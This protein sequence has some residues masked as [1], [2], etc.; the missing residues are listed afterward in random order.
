VLLYGPPWDDPT[1]LSKHHLASYLARRGRRVL[2]VEAPLGPLSVL[3]R[4]TAAVPELRHTLQAPRAVEPNLWVRRYFN[5]VPYHSVTRA[6]ATRTANL[7]GQRLL[8]R[9]LRDDLASLGFRDSLVIAGLPHALD[10]LPRLP[11]PRLLV[12]HCA[13]DYASVRGF[14]RSLST[15]EAELCRRADL[16]I[17]TSEPLCRARRPLNPHTHWIP[18]GAN[19][20]HFG[21]PAAPAAELQQATPRPTV[22]F[23]GAIAQWVDLDLLWFL[24]DIRPAW[25]LVLVGPIGQDVS[26]LRRLPNVH[27]LGPRPYSS[28]PSFLAAMD[29]A[30]VPFVRDAVTAN[31]D[32]IKVYEYLAAGVPVVATDLPGLRRLDHV[33]RLAGNTRDFLRAIDEALVAGRDSGAAERRVEAARHSWDNRFDTFSELVAER[34]AT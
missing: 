26:A 31:A 7:V 23:V 16:V 4:R 6:T 1:R 22:G 21:A 25:R 27:L 32:P 3:R 8:A 33:V 9:P 14:P 29:V 10:L 12:Y 2:Y 30:L 34:L 15:L 28:L 24:A 19:V 13:D 20:D 17:T 5:P 18:N 11:R